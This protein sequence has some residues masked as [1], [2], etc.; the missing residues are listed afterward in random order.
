M[1]RV[2]TVQIE[3]FG[4]GT[5]WNAK[6]ADGIPATNEFDVDTISE[7]VHVFFPFGIRAGTLVSLPDT[8]E[9][10]ACLFLLQNAELADHSC[11][12]A[13][14]EAATGETEEE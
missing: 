3:E 4:D 13:T 14:G 5:L 7:F 11:E 6:A 2:F 10:V 1:K 8:S 12:T 9:P